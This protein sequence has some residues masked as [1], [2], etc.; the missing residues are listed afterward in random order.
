MQTRPGAR[1]INLKYIKDNNSITTSTPYHCQPFQYHHPPP[2]TTT[3]S[4]MATTTLHQ[5]INL[6]RRTSTI[7]NKEQNK[8]PKKRRHQDHIINH[9]FKPTWRQPHTR[10]DNTKTANWQQSQQ[11]GEQLQQH[12]TTLNKI[13][14][15]VFFLYNHTSKYESI[16]I[17]KLQIQNSE[18][19]FK[20]FY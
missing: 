5:H 7:I 13:R 20:D 9:H 16:Q 4:A 10:E 11:E 1:V 12:Q 6:K 17:F 8:K 2:N 3:N 19:F 18:N 15:I 14:Y